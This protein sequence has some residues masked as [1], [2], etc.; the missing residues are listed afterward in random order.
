MFSIITGLMTYLINP[1]INFK[2]SHN[3]NGNNYYCNICQFTFPKNEKKYEHCSLCNI[4]IPGSDHHCGIFEKCI[5][6]KNLI[7]FYLFPTFSIILLIVFIVSIFFNF[8]KYE[9]K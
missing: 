4:C 6:R 8:I 2:E 7:C 5:G 9:K 3:N 1:G